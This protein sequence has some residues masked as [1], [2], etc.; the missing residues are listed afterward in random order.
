MIPLGGTAP[1]S[2][3]TGFSSG[4]AGAAFAALICFMSYASRSLPPL[5]PPLDVHSS[6]PSGDASAHIA[7]SMKAG[8]SFT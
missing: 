1:G 2:T 3:R 5:R 6:L 8:S 7:L 4:P